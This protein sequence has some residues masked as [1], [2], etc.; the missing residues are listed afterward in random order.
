MAPWLQIAAR[1]FV[2]LGYLFMAW[3]TL[4]NR[5]FSSAVRL[6]T[7]RG[8]VVVDCGPYRWRSRITIMDTP[9]IK[10][11]SHEPSARPPECEIRIAP[12]YPP[13]QSVRPGVD[14]HLT[15]IGLQPHR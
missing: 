7:D 1:V 4:T 12:A 14:H 15:A 5:F 11:A 9:A 6:Q 3:A 2:V 10:V 13:Y 8:Q